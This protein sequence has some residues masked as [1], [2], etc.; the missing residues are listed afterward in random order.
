MD[1]D[2]TIAVEQL[3]GKSTKDLAELAPGEIQNKAFI[4]LCIHEK[5]YMLYFSS[6]MNE[7]LFGFFERADESSKIV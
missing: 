3:R 5:K 1:V 7:S 6:R 2:N 4:F